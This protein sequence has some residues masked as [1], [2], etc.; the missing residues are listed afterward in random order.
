MTAERFWEG[1]KLSDLSREEWEA[2]CDGCGKCCLHK[3]EDESTG[4]IFRTN[5]ACRLLDLE[6]AQCSDYK[7]RRQHVPDC[8][9]LR[10]NMVSKLYW[11]PASCA[12]RLV[13]EGKPLPDWHPLVSG[14]RETVHAAGASI[15]GWAVSEIHAGDLENHIL[16]EDMDEGLNFEV[17][18]EVAEEAED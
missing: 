18:E 4:R 6:T 12:Y 1:R 10:P 17:A 3:L 11:L 5:L 2:L 15:R 14:S 9:Q 8:L 7:H 13:D 16:E